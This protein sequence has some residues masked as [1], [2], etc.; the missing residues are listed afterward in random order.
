MSRYQITGER[1]R[2]GDAHTEKWMGGG[3][4]GD[5]DRGE[6]GWWRV[7]KGRWGETTTAKWGREKWLGW[8]TT[9]TTTTTKGAKIIFHQEEQKDRDIWKIPVI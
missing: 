6:R 3:S 1:E 4:Y 5:I 9:T 2:E 8:S 7:G